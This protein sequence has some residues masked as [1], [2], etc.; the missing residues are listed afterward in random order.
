[1]NTRI[2]IISIVRILAIPTIF[3]GLLAIADSFLPVLQTDD[4]IIQSKEIWQSKGITYNV[5]AQ[6]KYSYSESVSHDFY[7]ATQTGMKLR[8]HL[9]PIFKEWK[10]AEL[11]QN[12]QVVIN[13]RNNDIFWMPAVGLFLVLPCICFRPIEKWFNLGHLIVFA[14]AEFAGILLFSKL[15]LVWL[16]F[17]GKM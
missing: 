15:I 7:V 16:G 3:V 1:M 12:D 10:Q 8:L 17:V 5:R 11:I 4:A 14:V 6:G 9:T 2:R 13:G